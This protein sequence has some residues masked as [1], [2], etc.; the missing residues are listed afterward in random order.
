MAR[1]LRGMVVALGLLASV[2]WT[3]GNGQTQSGNKNP[4]AAAKMDAA[5]LA[6]VIDQQINAR[7][8]EEDLKPSPL[9][10]DGE[11]LRRVYL[12]LIGVIPPSEKVV[13]FLDSTDPN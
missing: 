9:S 11:F 8:K 2:P 12:D 10:D 1:Q 4:R 13:A 6:K 5:A 7:L 3:M